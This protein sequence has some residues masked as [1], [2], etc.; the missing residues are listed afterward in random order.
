MPQWARHLVLLIS[1]LGWIA[2]VAKSLLLEEIP[3][4]MIVGFPAALWLALAGGSTIARNRANQGDDP[5][6]LDA[7]AEEEGDPA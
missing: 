3:S 4:A 2:I 5:A 7:A 1:M 6:A